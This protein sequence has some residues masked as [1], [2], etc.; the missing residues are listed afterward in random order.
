MKFVWMVPFDVNCPKFFTQLYTIH[1]YKNGNYIPL[2]FILL[3]GKSEELYR[4]AFS[5]LLHLCSENGLAFAPSVVHVNFKETVMKLIENIFP[6]AVLQC[7]RFHL[8]QSWG[9]GGEDTIS[10]T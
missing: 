9:G 1:G 3:P 6:S 7:C 8:S 2:V 5:S 4:C 10:G